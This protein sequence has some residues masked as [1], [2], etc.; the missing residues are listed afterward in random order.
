M[1]WAAAM[2]LGPSPWQVSSGGGSQASSRPAAQGG[3]P[4]ASSAF[5]WPHA[6]AVLKARSGGSPGTALSSRWGRWMDEQQSGTAIG[7][8]WCWQARQAAETKI[9]P[10]SPACAKISQTGIFSVVTDPGSAD[11]GFTCMSTCLEPGDGNG[12]PLS[13]T[14]AKPVRLDS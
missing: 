14:S 8:P 2:A 1:R 10:F 3:L 12:S 5:C 7:L 9:W 6:C 13:K 11:T 4:G